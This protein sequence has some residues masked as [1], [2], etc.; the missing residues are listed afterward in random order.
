MVEIIA[1]QVILIGLAA[2]GSEITARPG[3]A[4]RIW[5]GCVTARSLSSR[6]DIVIWLAIVG[7]AAAPPATFVDELAVV[8]AG[9]VGCAGEARR[10]ACFRLGV[11]FA[12]LGAVTWIA[13]RGTA[14]LDGLLA[15]P[16][17]NCGSGVGWDQ[18]SEHARHNRMIAAANSRSAMNTPKAARAKP[19]PV[20]ITVL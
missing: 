8:D 19:F 9:V 2:I 13:G 6:P 11:R 15:D 14:V 7:G 1:A 5:P 20:E 4:S 12:C 17:C 3:A 18:A 16:C 10:G